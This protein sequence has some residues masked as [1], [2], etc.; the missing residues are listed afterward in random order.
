[1][2][3]SKEHKFFRGNFEECKLKDLKIGDTLLV[4]KQLGCNAPNYHHKLSSKTCYKIKK[5]VNA[6]YQNHNGPNFGKQM[7]QEQKNKISYGL[8]HSK[9]FNSKEAKRKMGWAKNKKFTI[10]HRKNIAKALI[11][12]HVGKVVSNNTRKKLSKAQIRRWKKMSVNDRKR[13][14]S[15]AV[16]SAQKCPNGLEKYC[17]QFFRKNNINLTFVGNGAFMLNHKIPDFVNIEKKVIVEV[18]HSLY[19]KRVFGSVKKYQSL[20][21]KVF[22][23][24]SVFY[25]NDRDIHSNNFIDKL[26]GVR[27]AIQ[28]S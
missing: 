23:G 27:N 17:I 14:F 24:W 1:V 18:Y 3:A 22:L 15:N 12:T 2:L 8:K 16:K 10:Q 6:Y 20:R 4:H 7:N 11:G 9:T 19:K 26:E 21:S 25:F 5:R 13:I 28:E